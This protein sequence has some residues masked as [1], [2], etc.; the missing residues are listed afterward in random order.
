MRMV[1]SRE[2]EDLLSDGVSLDFCRARAYGRAPRMEESR[3]P[4]PS[5]QRALARREKGL[6]AE[7]IHR[8]FIEHL[9][10]LTVIEPS[11]RC[12]GAR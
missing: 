12:R 3:S 1:S 5:F 10:H 11:D 9:F 4:S 6:G 7:Q 2:A 8:Q